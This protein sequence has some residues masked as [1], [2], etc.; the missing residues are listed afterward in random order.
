MTGRSKSFD[1]NCL[2]HAMWKRF[3]EV[4]ICVW[5]ERV[6]TAVNIADDPSRHFVCIYMLCLRMST[7]VH[8]GRVWPLGVP[9]SNKDHTAAR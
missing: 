7:I 6:P 5:V 1:H 8:E 3:A 9:W 4:Q 2:V